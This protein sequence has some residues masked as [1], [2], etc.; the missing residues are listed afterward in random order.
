MVDRSDMERAIRFL[1]RTDE[2]VWR[3]SRYP[4]GPPA[5]VFSQSNIDALTERLFLW[6]NIVRAP[7]P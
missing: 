5:P 6:E 2:L 3:R 1:V 7:S 4:N